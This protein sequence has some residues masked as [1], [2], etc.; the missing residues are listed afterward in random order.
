MT[1]VSGLTICALQE[2][3]KLEQGNTIIKLV[4]QNMKYIGVAAND[5][6]VLR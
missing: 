2:V 3:R 5:S 6:D 1:T 4:M